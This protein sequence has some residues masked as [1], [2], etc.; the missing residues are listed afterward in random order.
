MN[1][2]KLLLSV[3]YS[4]FDFTYQYDAQIHVTIV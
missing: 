2:F 3:V 4:V 1:Q